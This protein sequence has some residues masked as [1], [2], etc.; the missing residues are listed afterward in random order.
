MI[1]RI[2]SPSPRQLHVLSR[3]CISSSAHSVSMYAKYRLVIAPGSSRSRRR[4]SSSP[5]SVTPMSLMICEQRAQREHVREVQV[6]DRARLVAKPP[7]VLVQSLLGHADVVDDLRVDGGVHAGDG[8]IEVALPT[9]DVSLH[10]A[11]EGD[12]QSRHLRHT[13]LDSEDLQPPLLPQPE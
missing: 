6:G 1:G 10:L 3:S 12:L 7:P 9:V 11:L 13:A 2:L 5:S 8:A 4:Y